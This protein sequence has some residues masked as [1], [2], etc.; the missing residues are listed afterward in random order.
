MHM[1]L[2]RSLLNKSL[3]VAGVCGIGLALAGCKSS[4][5]QE[6]VFSDA[7]PVSSEVKPVPAPT[8]IPPSASAT[9]ESPVLKA[10]TAPGSRFRTG[11]LVTITFSGTETLLPVHEERI[12]DDGTITLALI[13]SVIAQGKT[14]GELQKEIQDA[15]V[16]KYYT[17]LVTTVKTLEQV[18][19][20]GGEVRQAGRQPWA[21][22]TRVTQAIQSA[23]YFTDFADK[24]RVLLVRADGSKTVVNCLKAMRD[25]KL[26]PLVMPGDTITV[27]RR[28]W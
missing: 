3:L 16:P 7:P 19:Y 9:S 1:K 6:P 28:W 12:K 25:S 15:Y 24:K 4:S 8:T 27:Q 26:D 21:G 18:Y 5:G 13:G 10:L 14:A 11:D 17:R 22:E 2:L 20:V 23:G